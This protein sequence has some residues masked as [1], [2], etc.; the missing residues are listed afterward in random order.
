MLKIALTQLKSSVNKEENLE[1]MKKVVKQAYENRAKLVVFPEMYMFYAE[2]MSLEEKFNNAETLEGN[3]VKETKR[4]AKEYNLGIVVGIHERAQNDMRTYNTTIVVNNEGEVIHIYRKTHLYDAFNYSE[5]KRI[6]RGDNKLEPFDYLG[7]KI[8]L[9]VCYEVRFP[10]IA[11]TLALKGAELLLIPSAW[12]KGYNKEDQWETLVKARALENTV[13]VGT[14]NQIGN[15]FTGI[16]MFVDPMG[17]VLERATEEEEYIIYGEVR[18]ERLESVR[19]VLPVLA[20][21]RKELY[22]L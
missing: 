6:I 17:I 19:K 3:F 14:S 11:R 12:F 16:S 8:G 13:Y 21:R 22:E 2:K 20:Q 4:L 10:E 5:S 7:Y 9:M 18:K 15:D 1:E